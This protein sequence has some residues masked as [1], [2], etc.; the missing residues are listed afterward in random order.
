MQKSYL[1]NVD[2]TEMIVLP[3][4]CRKTKINSVNNNR[5]RVKMKKKLVWVC[6]KNG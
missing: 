2:F 6:G 1:T 4:I 5:T 3:K